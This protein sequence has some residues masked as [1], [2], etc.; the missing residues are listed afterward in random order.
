M[1]LKERTEDCQDRHVEFEVAECIQ[2]EVLEGHGLGAQE[3]GPGWRYNVTTTGTEVVTDTAGVHNS[4]RERGE[5]NRKGRRPV[6][7]P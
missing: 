6:S 7:K 3:E 4:L 1:D 2:T 5:C